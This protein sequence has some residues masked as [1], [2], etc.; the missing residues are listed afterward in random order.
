MHTLGTNHEFQADKPVVGHLY[1]YKYMRIVYIYTCGSNDGDGSGHGCGRG[2]REHGVGVEVR[3]F[4]GALCLGILA[5]LQRE[6]H[7]RH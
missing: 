1:L 2:R 7:H 3:Q 6:V 4:G 5:S